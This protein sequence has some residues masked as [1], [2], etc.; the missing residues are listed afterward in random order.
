MLTV[1]TAIGGVLGFFFL[2]CIL[3]GRYVLSAEAALSVDGMRCCLRLASAFRFWGLEWNRTPEGTDWRVILFGVR[4]RCPRSRVVLSGSEKDGM[5]VRSRRHRSVSAPTLRK[6]VSSAMRF[7]RLFRLERFFFR[8]TVGLGNPA[9]TGTAYALFQSVRFLFPETVDLHIFPH[10]TRRIVQG[11]AFIRLRFYMGCVV[12]FLL[13]TAFGALII[14][15]IQ[16]RGGPFH[17]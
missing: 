4:I 10:Y 12:F 11:D 15:A 7:F 6:I 2:F 14:P 8:G 1:F 9:A 16:N 3:L 17:D 13:R 5:G